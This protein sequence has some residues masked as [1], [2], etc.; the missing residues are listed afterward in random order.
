[1]FKPVLRKYT[2]HAAN[3]NSV[4]GIGQPTIVKKNGKFHPKKLYQK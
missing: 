2:G 1:M 4:Y 3:D